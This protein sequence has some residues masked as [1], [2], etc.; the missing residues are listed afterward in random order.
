[1][2][3]SFQNIPGERGVACKRRRQ[4]TEGMQETEDNF[5]KSVLSFH[6]VGFRD[7]T[8]HQA[9]QQGHLSTELIKL[10]QQALIK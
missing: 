1:M 4:G 5:W 8:Q 10:A 2:V 6:S 9:Y 7:R 3:I